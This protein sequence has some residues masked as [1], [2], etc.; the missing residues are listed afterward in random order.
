MLDAPARRRLYLMRHGEVSYF[1]DQ[2]QPFRPNTV[3]LNLA[4]RA[5]AEAAGRALADVPLDRVVTSGLDRS[6][7]TA[8]IV[9]AGRGLPI[10]TRAELR[11]IQPGRLADIPAEDRAR[12][13]VGAFTD[14]VTRDTCFLAGETFGA[15]LDRVLPCV[16]EL[17]AEPG[18]RHLLIVA[19][20]GVN[21][22]ILAHALGLDLAGF[23][24]FEQDPACINI[25]DVD[26]AGRWLVRLLNHTPYND[27]KRGL[28][29]TTMERLYEDY[30]RRVNQ[31]TGGGV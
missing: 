26:V 14:G 11:E 8:R 21:R 29:L 19:H 5:Q 20:G 7:E 2:G 1:D 30:R 18:W 12:V 17:L 24:C 27:A 6:V 3:P 25:L 31:N 13:F 10:E 28:E 9:V 22:A 15:L 23:A 4:G 16:R